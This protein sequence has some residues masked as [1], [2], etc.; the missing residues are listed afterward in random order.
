[1]GIIAQSCPNSSFF[2]LLSMNPREQVDC[3]RHSPK[4]APDTDR[5]LLCAFPSSSSLLSQI[6]K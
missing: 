5:W 4:D 1:M 3:D 2:F 6:L